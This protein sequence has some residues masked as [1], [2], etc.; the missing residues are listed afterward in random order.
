MKGRFFATTYTT[1]TLIIW[2]ALFS[3]RA[4]AAQG[5]GV[6]SA[7]GGKTPV[8]VDGLLDLRGV[9]L[10][11]EPVSLNGTWA[12]YW[13]QL[14]YPPDTP[15]GTPQFIPFP[16]LWNNLG[17]PSKGYA[18]YCLTIILPKQASH[19]ALDVPDCYTAYRLFLNGHVL[20]TSGSPDTTPEKAVPHWVN[21]TVNIPDGPDTLHLLL[22]MANFWHSRGGP[23][24]ELRIGDR[25][26]L[27]LE[28]DRTEA[29]DFLLCG[30]LFMGGLFFLGLYLFGRHDKAILFFSLFCVTYSYRLVGASFYAL[31]S[32]FPKLSWFLTI[33]L[34]Y[35]TLFLSITFLVEYV[36][37]LYPEDV[38]HKVISVMEWFC[39][40]FA[41]LSLVTPPS[42]FTRLITP[43]LIVMFA[44]I[45][46]TAYVYIQATRRRRIGSL[47]ALLSMG[48]LMVT[49]AVLNLE[50]LG[51]INETQGVQAFGYIS[52]FF[53]QS[54]ILSFR[55][56]YD[57]KQAKVQAE[58]GARAKSEFL[59]SM[60]HEIRTPLN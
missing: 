49:F 15:R 32:I 19:L 10:S 59:S 1:L 28:R 18:T 34:E 26:P 41:A 40:T 14:I 4:V 35:L 46:Y 13:H 2:I 39:L 51:G 17:L 21:K 5:E 57:L 11:D 12:L 7:A 52:F 47:Y 36:R 56:S 8:V 45:G 33:H 53:L 31:H 55:F 29:L 20:C 43:F 6:P 58:Q 22:Q 27:Y 16:R 44:Y 50:Y 9:N 60:S 23:F 42:V 24:K 30:C 25:A 3:P 37:Q 54:L 48:V 38:N